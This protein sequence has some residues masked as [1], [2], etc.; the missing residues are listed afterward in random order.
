MYDGEGGNDIT[1]NAIQVTIL[2]EILFE[3][4]YFS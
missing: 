2:I 3:T 4:P 1:L